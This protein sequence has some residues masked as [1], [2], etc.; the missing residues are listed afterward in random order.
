M[1]IA[2]TDGG[3]FPNPGGRGGWAFI[4]LTEAGE[5]LSE[6][7]G[8]EVPTTNNRME[9]QAAIEALRAVEPGEAITIR[10]DSR[11]VVDGASSWM[12]KWKA[13]GWRR[14]TKRSVAGQVGR[15]A[16]LRLWQELDALAT[17]RRVT[18]EWVRGHNGDRWNERADELAGE[19]AR[20]ARR[21]LTSSCP[22][23]DRN[24]QTPE[25]SPGT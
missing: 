13:R 3:C 10:S 4:L 8:G 7:S 14:S 18:W 1:K 19:G 25:C 2:Y 21:V 12:P 5:L 9:L 16:N 20:R 24:S 6:H 15:I 22:P 11:Y 17:G 23:C